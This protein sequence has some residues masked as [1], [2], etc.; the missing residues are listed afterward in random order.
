MSHSRGGLVGELLGRGQLIDQDGEA[1]PP[2]DSTDFGLFDDPK[3]KAELKDLKELGALLAEKRI[4]FSRF[5]RV[6]CPA[7]GTS[8]MRGRLDRWLNL[9]LDTARPSSRLA[10]SE[11]RS[12]V[13]N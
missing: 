8:L 7:R 5:V 1:R 12:A 3:Y 11:T 6:A 2:F 9:I 10:N 13:S 4:N